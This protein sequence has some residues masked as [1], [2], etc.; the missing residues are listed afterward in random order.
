M[1]K[2]HGDAWGRRFL[3]T[4]PFALALLLGA[5]PARAVH[6]IDVRVG[7]HAE[8]TRIVFDLDG[9][10]KYRL[11]RSGAGTQAEL[12]VH[13]D[14]SAQPKVVRTMSK[15]VDGVRLESRPE[16][17]VARIGLHSQDVHT[18]EE[19]LSSPP[20]IVIDVRASTPVEVAAAKRSA[21][22]PPPTVASPAPAPSPPRAPAAAPPPL[23][24]PTPRTTA[25]VIEAQADE[26]AAR[27][28]GEGSSPK[29]GEAPAP[30]AVPPP[31]PSEAPASPQ[32]AAA[33]PPESAS[34]P[35]AAAP[36]ATAPA[37]PPEPPREAANPQPGSLGA[38]PP[39]PPPLLSPRGSEAWRFVTGAVL[40]VLGLFVWFIFLRRQ[41][42]KEDIHAGAIP[43]DAFLD[44]MGAFG[45]GEPVA[46]GSPEQPSEPLPLFGA[47]SA[48]ERTLKIP[49][50]EEGGPRREED[51]LF[52]EG[53]RSAGSA[54]K[55]VPAS[56]LERPSLSL[57]ERAPSPLPPPHTDEST[58]RVLRDLEQR[59][60]QIEQRL[61]RDADTRERLERQVVAQTE[62]L[63]VQRAAIARTQRVL[64]TLSRPE[65]LATEPVIKSP[66]PSSSGSPD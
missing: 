33:P 30:A 7:Q 26:A 55:S 65:D 15:V 45:D 3:A 49:E 46:E 58:G 62:E 29:S 5:T 66:G 61:A 44:R 23:A 19:T 14:A 52:G 18:V 6:V 16:G 1:T 40:I 2:S 27:L 36:S 54:D 13:F 39:P 38:P 35:P 4:L 64:R 57:A 24:R 21:E 25:E 8:F 56:D 41:E 9:P 20:R 28:L 59:L 22:A 47:A 37:A 53:L 12:L 34:A 63:R 17:A 48:S 31:A 51:S 42:P 10:A 60:I 11:E 32:G 50:S 43:A